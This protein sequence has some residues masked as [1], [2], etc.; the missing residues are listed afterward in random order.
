MHLL[1][2]DPTSRGT[3]SP[4]SHLMLEQRK[5]KVQATLLDFSFPTYAV[6]AL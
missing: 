6:S 3:F 2:L 5:Y 4:H 1:P